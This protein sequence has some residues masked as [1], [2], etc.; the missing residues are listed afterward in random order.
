MRQKF[1]L[2]LATTVFAGQTASGAVSDEDI[3]HLR[4]QIAALSQRLEDLAVENAALKESQGRTEMAVADVKNIKSGFAQVGEEE[5]WEDRISFKGDLRLRYETI[6]EDGRDDRKRGRFRTRFGM[7]AK[8]TD[9]VK[10]TMQIASGGDNPVSTN[11]SFD[12]GFSTKDLGLDL[13][14]VD[15]KVNDN[16]NIYGGKMKNPLV[17]VGG[18][19][20]I[21]DSDLNPEGGTFIYQSEI[22]FASLGGFVVA[23]RSSS[24]DSLLFTGQGGVKFDMS[25]AGRLTAGIGYYDYSNT[26][27]NEPFYQGRDKGNSVDA[28]GNFIYDYNIFE[29][30]SEYE[31]SL[32]DWPFAVFAT[33][34]RNTEVDIEDTAYAFG[35]KAGKAIEKG[36]M[37]FSW[38]YM[39]LEADAVIGIFT[40]SDFADGNVDSDGHI[41]RGKYALSRNV[42][43]GGTLFINTL[44]EFEG[45]KRDYQRFQLDLEYKFN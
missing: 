22:F 3:E 2:L 40:D 5:S 20:L 27:G 37:E 29:V 13:A 24:D 1:F 23:E 16:M 32:G 25:D 4:Q 15:W 14:Y 42:A 36:T 18:A 45:N 17:R 34:A 35:V 11:Q 41:F 38:A 26:I 12:D 33:F 28:D 7:S 43:L 44:G 8:I 39:D 9:N 21:W 19:P 30:F 31:T 6:D 10:F